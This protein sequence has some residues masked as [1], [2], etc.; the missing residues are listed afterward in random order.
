MEW[1][2]LKITVEWSALNTGVSRGDLSNQSGRFPPEIFGFLRQTSS[3]SYSVF[4]T[5]FSERWTMGPFHIQRVYKRMVHFQ[6][7]TRNLFLTLHWQNLHR[8]QRQLSKFCMRCQQFAFH[9][10]CGAAGS[11]Y[12]MEPQQEEAFCVLRFEVSRSVITVQQYSY[13]ARFRKDAPCMV[14]LF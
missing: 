4:M 7:S 9:A 14:R 13:I 8:Q 5:L 2:A 6:K 12:K 1:G 11:V 3:D 10:Y